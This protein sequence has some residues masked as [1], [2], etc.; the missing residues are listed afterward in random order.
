MEAH[1]LDLLDDK[2]GNPVESLEPHGLARVEIDHDHLDFPTVPG[3]HRPRGIHQGDT[4]ACGQAGPRMHEGR[5]PVGQGDTHPGRQDGPLPGGE[6]GGL[7]GD[8]V[9]PRVAGVP[10]RRNRHVR[11]DSA[12][13]DV[14]GVT[15]HGF[16]SKA[17]ARLTWSGS[18]MTAWIS[19]GRPFSMK[20]STFTSMKRASARTATGPSGPPIRPVAVE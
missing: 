1:L 11:V 17:R 10:V 13:E 3:I 5:V 9:G 15:G 12:D 8:E 14:Y 20:W 4:A 2:L 18:D 19:C 6:L 16:T 7:G